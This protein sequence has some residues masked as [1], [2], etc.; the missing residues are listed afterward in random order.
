M[1]RALFALATV[2]PL[3]LAAQ[4]GPTPEERFAREARA[5][6]AQYRDARL[7]RAEGFKRV[8]VE[9]PFMGEHWV[10][11]AR[12][13]ENRFDPARPSVLIYVRVGGEPRLA[14]VAY[15]VMLASQ[16]DR[17]PA[18]AAPA[19]M[20]HEHNG[21]VADESLPIHG[22]LGGHQDAELPRLAILHAW[23]WVQNPAGMF[24]TDNTE[25]PYR[26]LG[27]SRRFR[28][29]GALHAASLSIDADQYYELMVRS[30]LRASDAEA[31]ALGNVVGRFRVRATAMVGESAA[32]ADEAALAAL[33]NSMWSELDAAL[34]A[35]R[36]DLRSLRERL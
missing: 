13:M 20:W 24:S 1:R 16:D 30:S 2:L 35:R 11:L 19:S 26:R 12:I 7:A 15:T 33:W 27:M 28:S 8:G 34:P 32:G 14:G 17:P 5:G 31:A 9:F 22:E 18:S 36:T 10:N 6:T 23:V 3:G 25:L 29:R 21:S 4:G